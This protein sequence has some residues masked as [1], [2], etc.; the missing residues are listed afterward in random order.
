M[1]QQTFDVETGMP[2]YGG[3]EQIIG[4][5][6]EIAGFGSTRIYPASGSTD[7]KVTQAKT[8]TGYIK[9]ERPD[10]EDLCVPFHGIEEV[11]SGRG[12][13]LTTGMLEELRHGADMLPHQADV[14]A[15]P[16][17]RGWSLGQRRRWNLA[18]PRRWRIWRPH[19]WPRWGRSGARAATVPIDVA[20]GES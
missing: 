20:G 14:T 7:A 11:I 4:T 10:R 3:N 5:V 16:Q 15:P 17:P 9:V 6:T 2:V 8:G 1:K 12:V 18:H 13:S 19:S